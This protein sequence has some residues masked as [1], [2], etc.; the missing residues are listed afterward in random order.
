MYK[1]R[2]LVKAGVA[3]VVSSLL[4]DI[5]IL[6]AKAN[7]KSEVVTLEAQKDLM[8]MVS[9]LVSTGMNKND[10]VFLRE[11]LLPIR[12]SGAHKPVNLEH[13]P[14]Q[15]VGHMTKTYVTLK[16]GSIVE[17]KDNKV[18][19]EFDLTSEAVIYK[20][21][22]P[23]IAQFIK[24]KADAGNLFVSIE[25]WFE[26]YDY[27]VGN[28]IVRRNE[29]TSPILDKH[30]RANGGDG[31]YEDKKL[32]RVLRQCLI[33][34]IG[35]VK[36]P[37]NPE[38]IVKS[39]LSVSSQFVLIED[40]AIINNMIG[41][42]DTCGKVTAM[43]KNTL[44]AVWTTKFENDLPDSSFAVIEKGGKKVDG[45]TEPRTYRHLPYKDASGKVDVPH[46]RNALARMNQIVA[47]SPEDSTERIRK[48]AKEVLTRVAK[49]VLKNT[50]FAESALDV[51]YIAA[52]E[53]YA[54]DLVLEIPED[55]A[56]PA[57]LPPEGAPAIQPT[58]TDVPPPP[59]VAVTPQM[60]QVMKQGNIFT[61]PEYPT[62]TKEE[63]DAAL[64]EQDIVIGHINDLLED[65]L[66]EIKAKAQAETSK[67]A[68]AALIEENL[69]VTADQLLKERDMYKD[70][71]AR[72]Y[73]EN[74]EL[75]KEK[76]MRNRCD[77]LRSMM[78]PDEMQQMMDEEDI[79]EMDDC[80]FEAVV[81]S[82]KRTHK[83]GAPPV[84]TNNTQEGGSIKVVA[85]QEPAPAPTPAP[86]PAPE[87]PP[88][89]PAAPVTEPAPVAAPAPTAPPAEPVPAPKAPEAPTT[90]A[91]QTVVAPEAPVVP[92]APPAEP[93]VEPEPPVAPAPVV[94]AVPSLEKVQPVDPPISVVTDAPTAPSITQQMGEVLIDLLS[95]SNPKWKNLK[96]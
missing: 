58:M 8:R 66:N 91:P 88:A 87:T 15:I 29:D 33:A 26:D 80:T 64:R 14:D 92:P 82:I 54:G 38:S 22:F 71:C 45:K 93:V 68:E 28:V 65:K 57:I 75:L 40:Q 24:E 49:K 61:P 39:V 84:S 16:D 44:A 52:F 74:C 10:D 70:E 50:K 78:N 48:V 20:F 12:T 43:D 35:I 95:R 90:P 76:K 67:L 2:L 1:T 37:A 47:T 32:G 36:N 27:L 56:P 94:D 55:P 72:L 13:D 85:N 83:C 63:Y 34:G 17:D 73:K 41:C 31:Y 59:E 25:M 69:A 11:E 51:E 6:A 86:A 53:T 46:L 5:D 9:I 42:M 77:V 60:E 21:I 89:Q 4:T 79:E 7:A 96:L 3:D 30:L 23:E 19:E 18:P 62:V 81:R